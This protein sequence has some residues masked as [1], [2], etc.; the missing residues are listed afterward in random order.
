MRDIITRMGRLG[1]SLAVTIV[2]VVLSVLIT[3]V[4]LWVTDSG[5]QT[6]KIALFISI[7]CPALIAP[8]VTWYLIGLL[9]KLHELEEKQRELATYDELTGTMNRRTFFESFNTLK[10][11]A[12]RNHSHLTLAYIDIDDFKAINDTY[13][14]MV[15]DEVLRSFADTLKEG[16]R[17]S[18]IIARMG[19]EEF[20]ILLPDTD[21]QGAYAI[22][23][24]LRTQ[25]C[26]KTL[27]IEEHAINLSI[28]VGLSHSQKE[29][30]LAVEQ[31]IKQADQALYQAKSEGKNCIVQY[32]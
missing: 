3:M 8:M 2:S 10:K 13:G 21:I 31:L 32:A 24:R 28:S 27:R 1:V 22:L 20:A 25:I 7:L 29:K 15:G 16:A 19:G 17:G 14:H 18:D 12:D 23:E 9:I 4:V 5:P 26:T 11:I 6:Y 30:E